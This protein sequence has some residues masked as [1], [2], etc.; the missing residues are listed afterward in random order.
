MNDYESIMAG[1]SIKAPP[2]F[3]ED[4]DYLS[5]KNDLAVW[6]MFTDYAAEKRGPAVY[7]VLS[8]KAR[9][10]V[11]EIA[12]ANLAVAGGVKVITDK[13]DGIYT[14]DKNTQAY[15]NFQEFYQYRRGSGDTFNEFIVVY[16]KLYNKI[17]KYD[18]TVPDGVKA[19]FSVESCK[20]HSGQ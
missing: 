11:R 8:G 20:F 1:K 17:V 9:D 18:M 19:C 14:K 12:A 15:Q 3:A 7:L 2:V 13:L 16:E 10:A 4:D 5:W 6:E